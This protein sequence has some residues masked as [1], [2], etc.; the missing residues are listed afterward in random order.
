[1]RY[2]IEPRERRYIKGY[3]F[4]SFAKN[5]GNKYGKKL[6]NT[7]I[8]SGTNFNSKYGKKLTDTAIKT[9]KD[10][11]TIAGQIKFKTAMLKSS[12][13]GYSDAYILVKGTI[14]IAGAGADAAARQADERDK[15]VAFKNCA[16]FTN[17]II[18]INNTQVDNAKDIDIVMSMYNLIVGSLLQYFRDEPN[19]NLANSGSFKSKITITGK[20]PNNDDE[21]DVEIMVPLKYFSNFWRTLEMPLINCEVNLILTWSSTCVITNST[22]AETFKITDTKLYI[23][24]VTLSTQENTKLLQQLKS[25]FKRVINWNKYLS[26]P[27]SFRRNANLNSLVEPSFQG[28]NR[29]FVLAFEGDT[30]R[31]SHSGNYLPNVER[32]DYNIMNN[33]EKLFDQPIK[34]NKITYENIRKIATGQGDDYTTGCLLDYPY[35]TDTYKMIAVDLSKQK[36]LDTDPRA[37]QQIN[38]TANL[39]R[40]GNTRVYFILEEAKETILDFSQGTVI[41]L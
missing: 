27:E 38:F 16:P 26:K 4:L 36:A 19:D 5:F 1:M 14:T 18:E 41:V 8:E 28:I 13:C 29:L 39:D 24:A 25:G 30:Q 7:A 21:K 11:A 31:T 33:G 37:I 10:F 9:G 35:F 12:L 34:N 2:S 20:T 32:K 15:G 40:A 6:M 23:P 3:G 22:G 17:C